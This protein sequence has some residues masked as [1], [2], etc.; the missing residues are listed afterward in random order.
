MVLPLTQTEQLDPAQAVRRN[1]EH[2]E[3]L[4]QRGERDAAGLRQA[5]V[6]EETLAGR[7]QHRLLPL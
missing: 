6:L 3:A 1:C 5:A 4:L 7:R 2:K